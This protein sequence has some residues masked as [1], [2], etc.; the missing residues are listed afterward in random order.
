MMNVSEFRG[1]TV[2]LVTPFLPGGDVDVEQ[3]KALIDWHVEEGT[4]VILG[5]GTTGEA[6]TLST[7]EHKKVM[8]LIV[9][10]CAG[11]R[12]VIC[13]AGSNSTREAIGLTQF[14]EKV[15]CDGVLS[16]GPY[17][18]KPT[19]EGFFQHFG[20]IAACT[21]LPVILYN[22]PGRT[23]SNISAET[24]LR[25]AEIENIVG[26]KEASGNFSQI[27]EILRLRP[28][29]FL[30][31]SGDDAVALPLIALGGDGVISVVANETPRLLHEMVHAAF[32]GNWSKA[33]EIHYRLLPLMEINFIETNPIPVKTA[34]SMME[35]IHDEFRLPMV[36]MTEKNRHKLKAV[37]AEL[38]LVS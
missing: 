12:P 14:A 18:N 16:V 17:Y 30:V 6:S 4:D 25:L 23:G 26:V 8:E 7:E 15:G 21:Q 11:R 35:R 22:V 34:L 37:L 2:A 13:G 19:Q 24:T 29:G 3:L 31:L 33:R 5:T 10:Y 9:D 38:G 36:K 20:E 28:E 27:M 32:A 1:T